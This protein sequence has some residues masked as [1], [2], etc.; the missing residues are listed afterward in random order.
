[1]LYK[2]GEGYPK[3]DLAKARIYFSKVNNKVATLIEETI[4][5]WDMA[6]L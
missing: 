6:G 2:E 4:R 5:K 1:M 3:F